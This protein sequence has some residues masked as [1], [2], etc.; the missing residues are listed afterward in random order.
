MTNTLNLTKIGPLVRT[1]RHL[2]PIQVYWRARS[3]ALRS[4]WRFV[5]RYLASQL[6]RDATKLR[7]FN[8]NSPTVK[9]FA[10]FRRKRAGLRESQADEVVR[11]CFTLVNKPYQFGDSVDWQREDIKE[12]VTLAGFELHYQPYLEDLALSWRKTRDSRYLDKYVELVQWWIEGN[13]P[14]GADFSRFSWSPYVISERI[15]NWISSCYWAKDNLPQ[16]FLSLFEESLACQLCFLA[17]NLERDLQGNHL[18]QNLCGLAVGASFFE[19]SLAGSFRDKAL[20]QLA[21][22]A[23]SQMLADGMHEER[24]FFYH[25]KATAELVEVLAVADAGGFVRGGPKAKGEINRIADVTGRMAGFLR[26]TLS[27]IGTLPLL[28]DGEEVLRESAEWVIAKSSEYSSL[29]LPEN[30]ERSAGSG[31]LMGSVGPWAAV[32]DVGLPGPEH[33]LGHAH[34]DHLGFELWHDGQKLICDSG[35]ST[36]APGEQRRWYRGTAAHNTMKV[37]GEDSLELW[38]SFRVGRWPQRSSG[39]VIEQD[40]A[41]VVWYGAHDGYR[42]L[43]GHPCH[44]RWLCMREDLVYIFD[45]IEGGGTHSIGSFLHLH[46]AVQVNRIQEGFV[47]YLR[48]LRSEALLP[49]SHLLDRPCSCSVW[50]WTYGEENNGATTGLL[51]CLWPAKLQADVR[52]VSSWYAPAFSHQMKNVT[53][54]VSVS[55]RLPVELGWVSI[56]PPTQAVSVLE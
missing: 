41:H 52:E 35:N 7:S 13:P 1:V 11:S 22:T 16:S 39:K 48:W 15:R 21:R 51:A 5:P 26:S 50:Q 19:G 46:P 10:E 25:L 43:E 54:S 18:L 55:S 49:I 9:G 4:F 20:S 27:E 6:R 8:W 23:E 42:H 12:H 36:Y 29:R 44:K 47:G 31:Y 3:T 40:S 24:S 56:S 38:S 32:F 17:H 14:N 33:Q 37:D 34:A 30:D 53:L 2:K 45:R 28:N